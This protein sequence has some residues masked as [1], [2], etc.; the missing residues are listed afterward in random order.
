MLTFAGTIVF[1]TKHGTLTVDLAG[2][3]NIATGEFNATGPITGGTGKFEG[4][5]GTLTFS[6]VENLTTGAFT[7]TITGTLCR[8]DDGGDD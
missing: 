2:T 4:S 7:E 1:T 6:G 5:T 3:L 8:A